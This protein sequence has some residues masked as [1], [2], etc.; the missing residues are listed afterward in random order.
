MASS[1]ALANDYTGPCLLSLLQ[2]VRRC[3]QPFLTSLDAAHLMQASRSTTVAILHGYTFHR[4]F[5]LSSAGD[6]RRTIALYS[7]Y[8]IRL[9]GVGLG[10]GWQD[11]LLDSDSGRPLLPASLVLLVCGESHGDRAYHSGMPIDRAAC[12]ALINKAKCQQNEHCAGLDKGSDD[13][14]ADDESVFYR[15]VRIVDAGLAKDTSWDVTT[16]GDCLGAFNLPIPP[17]ALPSGLRVLQLND[18][19]NQPLAVG[20]IPDTVTVLQ[21]DRDFNQPLAIGHLPASLT[22]LIVG[23]RYNHPLLPGVLPAAL[24]RL[25]L[26]YWQGQLQ[27]GVLP[28]HLRELS[29]GSA[30]NHP[31]CLDVI[32]P[33]VSH[34]R[35]GYSF[36]QP[37]NARG[38][39]HGLVHLHLSHAFNHPLPP[40]ILPSS[41]RE[42]VIGAQ[43]V[44]PLQPGSLPDGLTLLAFDSAS[45]FQHVLRPG[46]IPATVILLSLGKW[47]S[48]EL[49]KGGIPATLRWIRLHRRYAQQD[50]RGVLS[51]STRVVWWRD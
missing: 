43:F 14:G 23:Y 12:G 50:L 40:H 6:A 42:L 46:V 48:R 35:L 21:L 32:P 3:L 26:G 10:A 39:S 33:S 34:L 1:S 24:E 30:Y 41:L 45:R 5:E 47:Y 16:F 20:S 15:H 17:G 4:I 13:V 2:P 7:R 9:Y 38:F 19:F 31:I 25:Q 51:P 37:L 28:P 29:F 36:N 11:P 44:L 18:A 8:H 22:H 49:V 27:P